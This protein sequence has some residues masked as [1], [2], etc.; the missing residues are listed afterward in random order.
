MTHDP[1]CPVRIDS[2]AVCQCDLIRRVVLR[3]EMEDIGDVIRDDR[4]RT[5]LA[6]QTR[7]WPLITEKVQGRSVL[8]TAQA[9][10]DWLWSR[11]DP[12]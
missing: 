1:F 5:A 12:G 4:Q 11:V 6:W 7:D 2:D 8:G 3:T 10:T 9:V